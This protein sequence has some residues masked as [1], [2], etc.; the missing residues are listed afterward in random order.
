MTRTDIIY[1][2]NKLAKITKCPGKT[3]FEALIHVLCYL[4][5]NSTVGIRFYSNLS[6][7]PITKMLIAK[8][9]SQTHPFLG[10]LT[11]LGMMMWTM[12]EAL[13]ASLSR[14]WVE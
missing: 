4:R 13:A 5:D 6:E 10:S 11:H 7:A 3:H 1:A 8:N 9:I 12:V 2:V 14:T